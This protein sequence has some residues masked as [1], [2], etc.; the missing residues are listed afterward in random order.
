MATN[1]PSSNKKKDRK[2]EDLKALMQPQKVPFKTPGT[3]A[4]LEADLMDIYRDPQYVRNLDTMREGVNKQYTDYMD[5]RYS[6]SAAYSNAIKQQQAMQAGG[7]TAMETYQNAFKNNNVTVTPNTF[8]SFWDKYQN[9]INSGAFDD[10]DDYTKWSPKK[11]DDRIKELQE[12]IANIT[13][14]QT[15]ALTEEEKAK[16][17]ELDDLWA[18]KGKNTPI[19]NMDLGKQVTGKPQ[20]GQN[21]AEYDKALYDQIH[22]DGAYDRRVGELKTKAD[23]D[24]FKRDIDDLWDRFGNV[25]TPDG[26][27]A[28]KQEL[29]D[30]WGQKGKYTALD[31]GQENIY[32]GKYGE[33][34]KKP[35]DYYEGN[36]RE[37]YDKLLYDELYG[38]GAYEKRVNELT[39]DAS[40]D[41][42][43]AEMDDMWAR[44]DARSTGIVNNPDSPKLYQIA[45]KNEELN[46]REAELNQYFYGQPKMEKELKDLQNWS[47]LG[48]K[49]SE[50]EAGAKGAYAQKD[51]TGQFGK[52]NIDL[53]NRKVVHNEDGSISTVRSF[54]ANFDGKEV[55]LPT[56]IDGKI[57]SEEEA[58]DHYLK[59]GE[60]LGMFDT[61]EEAD[62]Y[63]QILSDR[64]DWYYHQPGLA[65][66]EVQGDSVANNFARNRMSWL[67][68]TKSAWESDNMGQIYLWI[69]QGQEQNQLPDVAEDPLAAQRMNPYR[70][71]TP[72]QVQTFNDYF[73]AN[74][75]ESAKAY[76]D[77]LRQYYINPA[78]TMYEQMAARQGAEGPLGA[79]YGIGSIFEKPKAGFMGT[80]GS[81][82][83]LTGNDEAAQASSEWYTLQ[84]MNDATRAGRTEVWGQTAEDL[85]GAWARKP[86]E[87]LNSVFYSMADMTLAAGL[88]S[89]AFPSGSQ[90]ANVLTQFIMS[91]EAAS[92]TMRE[93]LEQHM[94]PTEAALRSIGAGAIEWITEKYSIEQLLNPNVKEMLRSKKGL[95]S[96]IAKNTIAE[97]FEEGASDVLN[98]ALDVILSEVYG[99]EN[100]NEEAYKKYIAQGMSEEEAS[101]TVLWDNLTQIGTDMLAGSL[102][103]FLMSGSRVGMNA[104]GMKS[105]GR[106]IKSGSNVTAEGVT[107]IDQVLQL[108]LGMKEGTQSRALAEEIQKKIESGKT[109]TDFEMGRL[110]QLTAV[111]AGEQQEAL[112]RDSVERTIR[113]SITKQGVPAQEAAQYSA[114]ITGSLMEGKSLTKGQMA[115]LSKSE[116][117]MNVWKSY[118]TRTGA[119]ALGM[120]ARKAAAP[121]QS[122][123]NRLGD[124]TGQ[125]NYGNSVI[126]AEI[127]R[128]SRET[129]SPAEAIDNLA[130]RR[131]DLM[132]EDF[133]KV[134]KEVLQ[135]DKKIV[136]K[137]RFLDDAMK[138]RLAAMTLND[139]LPANG[140]SAESA[141]KLYDTAR[142]EFDAI[143]EQRIR[144]QVQ[145]E[146]G[147]GWAKFNGAEYGTAAFDEAIA[148]Q[149]RQLRNQMRMIGEVATRMGSRVTFIND[150]DNPGIFG[151]EQSDGSI[152]I[153]IAGKHRSGLS[154]HMMVT[155]SHEMT[156]W[157]EQNSREGYNQLRKYVLDSLRAKGTNIEQL[158]VSSIDNQNAVLGAD[159]GESLTINGAMAE[160]VARSCENLLSSQAMADELAKTN[161]SLYNKVKSFVKNFVAR[162]REAVK[163]MN[164]SLSYE[165]RALL[166]ETEK[167]AKI[168]LGA[169]EEAMGRDA[170]EGTED[171]S[172]EVLTSYSTEQ[173]DEV[174]PSYT[175]EQLDNAYMKAVEEGNEELMNAMVQEA[176]RRNGYTTPKLYHGT[177]GFGFTEFDL[178]RGEGTVFS[179]PNKEL[180][181]AY[182]K[183]RPSRKI[184]DKVN[185]EALKKLHGQQLLQEA[186]KQLKGYED[187]GLLTEEEKVQATQKAKD[188]FFGHINNFENFI[189][190]NALNEEQKN[191]ATDL[192]KSLRKIAEA[193][194]SYDAF[195]LW[196]DYNGKARTI[197]NGND[198]MMKKMLSD[199]TYDEIL[200]AHDT[201]LKTWYD[202]DI[203]ASKENL[204]EIKQDRD[205]YWDL[206]DELSMGIY[207]LYGKPG[208]QLT[209][210]GD[211]SKWNK[212]TAP[213]ELGLDGK[214]DTRDIAWAAKR[215]KYDSVLLKDVRDDGRKKDFGNPT[216]IY[217]FFGE[218]QVK[219]ADLVTYDD[220]G[221]VIPLSERFNPEN[222][223]IRYSTEQLDAEYQAA[224]ERGDLQRATDMLMDRLAETEGIIPFNAPHGYGGQHKDIAKLIKEGTPEAVA[225]A[226]AD[227]ARFVPENGV[228]IP[229]PPHEGTV[230][231]DT[232]TMILANAIGKL[233]GRPVVVALASDPRESRYKAKS[234]GRKGVSAAEMG[235]RQVKEIPEG[236]MPIFIDNVVGSGVTADAARTAM[237]G[238]ITL[239]Y[240]KSTQSKGIEGLKR[241]TVTYDSNGKLI[242]LSQRFDRSIRNVNY[243]MEQMDDIYQEA[244][245]SGDVETQQRMVDEAAEKAFANSK[246]RGKD[247]KLL[248]MYHG[249]KADFNEFRRDYIGSTGRFEG[250][251]FNFTPAEGRAKSYGGNVLA[252]YLNIQK[253]LSAE[254]KTITVAKLAAIIRSADPTGDNIISDYA[255][256]TRDYGSASFVRREALTAA[257]NI[258]ESSDN[259]VDIYS[260]ISA[261]DSDAEGLIAEFEKLG[262]DGLIHYNDDG[263]IKTAVAF[264]S[265]QFKRADP[266]TY[267]DDKQPIKLS[268]RFNTE[269][270]DIRYSIDQEEMHN[271]YKDDALYKDSSLYDYD[272]LLTLPDIEGVSVVS[273][274]G[275]Y[276]KQNNKI[277][278]AKIKV[279]GLKE[280]EK[281]GTKISG[282]QGVFVEN[283]YTGRQL[284]VTG[285]AIVHGT[286]NNSQIKAR[287][288]A[289]AGLQLGKFAREALPINGLTTTEQNVEGTY[290]MVAPIHN[291]GQITGVA[292]L[293][294][295]IRT[296]T[297]VGVDVYDQIH[298]ANTRKK[299]GVSYGAASAQSLTSTGRNNGPTSTSRSS[300]MS[301]KDFLDLVNDTFPDILSEDVLQRLGNTNAQGY[302][303][304]RK[305]FSMEDAPDM[306]VNAW[307]AGLTPGSLQTEDERALLQAWKDLRMKISMSIKRQLDYRAKIKRLESIADPTPQEREDLVAVRNKLKVQEERQARLEKDMAKVTSQ[308]GFAGMMYQQNMVMRDFISG[309]TQDEVNNTVDDMVHEV[310]KMAQEIA[311]A[312]RELEKIAAEEG[313]KQAEAFLKKTQLGEYAKGLKKDYHS[314]MTEGEIRSRMAEMA[315]RIAQG[316]TVED[317][318]DSA[319]ELAYDLARTQAGYQGAY[320]E[321]ADRLKQVTIVI[322]QTQYEQLRAQHSSI[323]E[324]RRQL[325]GT[326][327]KIVYD[328]N[329][330]GAGTLEDIGP[331]SEIHNLLPELGED[332]GN[333]MNNLD[334]FL[335]VAQ[336]IRDNLE[337]EMVHDFDLQDATDMIRGFA[338][339]GAAEM[340]GNPAMATQVRRL[341]GLQKADGGKAG[342]LAERLAN[343]QDYMRSAMEKGEQA[344]GLTKML[345]KDVDSAIN[346]Y[347]KTAAVAAKEERRKVREDLIKQLKSE[348]GQ[349]LL[350]EQM[351]WRDL[352]E[353]D[354]TVREKMA[355]NHKLRQWITTD[356]SRIRKLLINETDQKN[357]PEHM[358][359]LARQMLKML[360]ENDMIG[361]KITEVERA[362]LK[363]T[364]RVLDAMKE[365][366]AEFTIDDLK[367]LD[368]EEVQAA[369][370]DALADLEDGI[371]FYN[372]SPGSDRISN[373]QAFHNALD[374]IHGAVDTIYSV[375]KAQ[376]SISFMDRQILVADA[377]EDIRR[378]M[379]R[380]RFKG[381]W[382]GR[383]SKAIRTTKNAV[384]YGNMT[385]V[386]FI[387]NLLNKGMDEQWKEIERGENQYGLE[388]KKAERYV[389]ELAERTGYSSWSNKKLKVTLGGNERTISIENAMELYA[390]WRREQTTNPEMSEHLTKGGVYIKEEEETGGK[391][392]REFDNKRAVRVT[393]GEI[394]AIY[395]QLTDEQKAYIEGM[396][397]YLS[398]DMS[399]LGN[400]ASM[401]MHGIKKYKEKYYF[402]MKVWDGVKSARSDKGI[403]GTNENRAAHFSWSKR[404]MNMARNALVIGNFTQDAVNHIV[405]MITYNT[406]APAIENLNRVLNFQFTEGMTEDDITKRN[407]RIMFAENYGKDAL[408][409]LETFMK[410]LNGGAVQDQRKTL[411]D[412]MLAIFKKN[413][414]AGSL[415]VA[416]QQPLSYVRA[417]M[418]INPK[419]LA[420]ALNP[421]YWKGSHEEMTKYSGVAVIK[422][423]G[424][425]DMNFGQSAADSIMPEG[426]KT[427]GR[428]AY[429]WLSDKTTM[430]PEMMDRMT[431]TR[432][433]SAVKAEQA[434]QN[435]GMD[436]K[437]DEFLQK[438][439][440]RFNDVMRKTQ[441]YDSVLV[442]SSNMRSQNLG[443]KVMTSFMAEPTLTLNVLA[444]AVR[445]VNLPGGKA[446]LAK[447]GATYVLSAVFQALVKAAMGTGRSPDKKKTIEEN[448]MNKFMQSFMG[449][450]NPMSL[451]PG[452][453]DLIEVLK[454]GELQDD[455]MGALG[456]LFSVVEST[457]K[458]I[459]GKQDD[460]YRGLEDTVGQLAQLF[461]N[462]P[463]KNLM[464]DARAM[465]NWAVV[466]PY[467]DR[468]TSG[469]VL[470]EQSMANFMTGDNLLGVLNS[471]L[472]DAGYKTTN[473]AYYDRMMQARE[474]GDEERE[475][476]LHEYL[477]LARGVTDKTISQEM[478]KR[479]KA[480]SVLTPE[481]K[482]KQLREDGMK[483]TD[484]AGWIVDEYEAG[485]LT[486]TEAEKLYVQANPK[487]DANDAYFMFERKEQEKETGESVTGGDYYKL[488]A[489]IAKGDTAAASA[490]AKDLTAHGYTSEDVNDHAK[491]YITKKYRAGEIT[492]AQAKQALKT[493]RKDLDDVDIF[494]ML[495]RID[496]KN[497]T[498]KSAGS[499]KYYRLDAAIEAN[500]ANEITRAVNDMM[501]YGGYDKEGVL[502]GIRYFKKTYLAAEG[503]EKKIKLRNAL[504]IAFKA[505]G[506]SATEA[507]REID[508]W[509]P[510]KTKKKKTK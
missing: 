175:M 407:L 223:D 421:K 290:A 322:G 161:P 120:E 65:G 68:V 503:N 64:Q 79:V 271:R 374:R 284:R 403:S 417:A 151:Y 425:F 488:D 246:V 369:V 332:T 277:D 148:G 110:A 219:S 457:Q 412:R 497:E 472:G 187:Y 198:S 339:L 81:V 209:I 364:L 359:S 477:T 23:I 489:A 386:Y 37:E 465:W 256:E 471:W 354:K 300:S 402:P 168:W 228:L 321:A 87:L 303:K 10:G 76:I 221:E 202:G 361:R 150:E 264:S 115:V 74:D 251:G 259:D 240:A 482:I 281:Y 319:S 352:I 95:A 143:D 368:D 178:E 378:D 269:K 200:K 222:P 438:C 159:S 153:N 510:A 409:Y 167:I 4:R 5:Q 140:M 373:L 19:W 406:M 507:T 338:M 390:I 485:N 243:S 195:E 71:M 101:N 382:K 285:K 288:N 29:S 210:E 91:S 145:V 72:E 25:P 411:R 207:E 327:V 249:T 49:V 366:D 1:Y 106:N 157:L 59:T 370:A 320:G 266:V 420:Q 260:F 400:K 282:N 132:S 408:N 258:W 176:A 113:E 189:K 317:I 73:H 276:I 216:D 363:E 160:I 483:D 109:P 443:M 312:K 398:N 334:K 432:M 504:T 304:G 491:D 279:D 315:L 350:K 94:D 309:R 429:E 252:G 375:I 381:E 224:V 476:E 310:Q 473:A 123:I 442:K 186:K 459:Q 414:V 449:E 173:L 467:A 353:K 428:A 77:A 2:E 31:M 505:A 448:M 83:A 70:F 104:V 118:N 133:A 456:K 136:N 215:H 297:V 149:N 121:A 250:S 130:A 42:F 278:Q 509:K 127:V 419:Y 206:V 53:N 490:A 508:S 191:K 158:I 141:Q 244:I 225:R 337:S 358:K 162:M 15:G 376:Q 57:V 496:Y 26:L 119:T 453:S 20:G 431:W 152:T 478:R 341:L 102:S 44:Y 397:R 362:D 114:I 424:R 267:G 232:D 452:Y 78:Q 389:A 116:P 142:A 283:K 211:G 138:I 93:Q 171:I 298:S 325:A 62:E 470:K 204:N 430:L 96:F 474:A 462:I 486:K 193:E 348:H 342:E 38:D 122:I 90:A 377:A 82:L 227:M 220:Q 347:N 156:H 468:A 287:A 126:A 455:A 182:S 112:V 413:A 440:E 384:V 66:N 205:I 253:P 484:I 458:I 444:D 499:G 98:I 404:R 135:S 24:A 117:A 235:F 344:K 311:E 237:G 170:T 229:M 380:S 213:E 58:I 89:A 460:V 494:W 199:E 248:K 501:K 125:T 479:M 461:T 14:L 441:V 238:G 86:A 80:M 506:M 437:S 291:N 383:G 296:N 410:D 218:S 399:E 500:K 183:E 351:K 333:M 466:R 17:K 165:A 40:V 391:L 22:G 196:M 16:K 56:V 495:D 355:S 330:R 451:I 212:L 241:A 357:I 263:N 447:A 103:G 481:E 502:K 299:S 35:E 469:A 208:R 155:L 69:Q 108:S 201:L 286:F 372:A 230:K 51:T 307:M 242:P 190:K 436:V 392:Q 335:G 13:N 48:N 450:V 28:S 324:L 234:E 128:S 139:N 289:R 328:K 340:K 147:E 418:M 273:N 275:S 45:G 427:K 446:V 46:K 423:M 63:A 60:Y 107:G 326:G 293:T 92:S 236:S 233:T 129:N 181:E 8:G 492:N 188:V 226:A 415:S 9:A 316:E 416:L 388:K 163:G 33:I 36:M 393:D 54:T 367:M 146:P 346:Y 464:R 134:A 43:E 99:H 21:Q 295:E 255:R 302:W 434:A 174:L 305:L 214:Q 280:A 270:Q 318:L 272:Y 184:K 124:L 387:K 261:A 84:G 343:A 445:N 245:D 3:N 463:A 254:K 379:S 306:D 268:E 55:L 32:S 7:G 487:K 111:E 231:A 203:Y 30:I 88:G 39:T 177:E 331:G 61:V 100:E 422:D 301:I 493:F 197:T 426:A 131:S 144:Q 194:S 345:K 396:V 329:L 154:H 294:V 454:T 360:T 265:N 180:A 97:G 18:L 365:T 11:V 192:V 27:Q 475:D 247:G 67:G 50:L 164:S 166:N 356:Y 41:A 75:L 262:Y 239:S 313:V 308:E 314:R 179:T 85:L 498:G 480:S 12:E 401:R 172:S 349:A 137:A 435:P 433:W 217:I 385:P 439:A 105:E 52:G 371:K 185:Y 274:I 257:R 47:K 292:L 34:P 405:E 394:L 169:R 6:T 395:D 336:S 323:P